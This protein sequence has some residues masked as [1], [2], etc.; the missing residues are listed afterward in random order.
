M[1][2]WAMRISSIGETKSSGGGGLCP[3]SIGGGSGRV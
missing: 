2:L 3:S 1:N